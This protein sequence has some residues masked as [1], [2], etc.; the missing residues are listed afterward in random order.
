MRSPKLS[1]LFLLTFLFL[2]VAVSHS[3]SGTIY[4]WTDEEGNVGFTDDP[5]KIPEKYRNSAIIEGETPAGQDGENRGGET[6]P[7]DENPGLPPEQP[8]LDAAGH[9]RS[10]WQNRIKDLRDQQKAL[11]EKKEKLEREINAMSNP[12][13]YNTAQ[14]KQLLQKNRE[15]VKAIERQTDE[16]QHQLQDVIP[17]EA[18]RSNAP[19]GWLR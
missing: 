11:M 17:D 8:D 4:Q 2:F 10:Y 13:I 16:I 18:R 12:L 3:R 6:P 5:S 15:E 9:D 19:P 1:D 14:D 7:A